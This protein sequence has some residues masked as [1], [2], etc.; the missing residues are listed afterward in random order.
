[1][2]K[3]RKQSNGCQGGG[4]LRGPG[5][6]V[7]GFRSTD[8][9]LQNSHR[10]VKY[11]IGIRVNNI[12][13]SVYGARWVPEIPGGTL[14]QVYDCLDNNIAVHMKLIKIILNVSCH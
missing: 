13:I 2:H 3:H 7:K 6:K 14:C 4:E 10:Y 9:Q 1:M 8:W 12:V 5:E 11:N